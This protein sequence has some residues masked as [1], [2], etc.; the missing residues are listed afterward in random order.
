MH[1][2]FANLDGVRHQVFPLLPPAY[3]AWRHGDGGRA[4]H[5]AAQAGATHWRRVCGQILA[6]QAS[7]GAEA[8][9]AI[10]ALSAAPGTFL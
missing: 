7:R 3:A 1:F 6:L 2:W 9:T 4:L 8:G 10:E 5:H